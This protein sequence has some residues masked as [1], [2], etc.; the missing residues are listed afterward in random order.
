MNTQDTNRTDLTIR[1]A[2]ER[3]LPILS[4][5]A[6]R[7]TTFELPPWRTATEIAD[8][9]AAAMMNAVRAGS[10]DNEVL[11]AE[12][13]GTV[14][15]CLHMVTPTDF[16]GRRHAHISV[17]ATSEAAEGT[18]VGRMLIAHAERW[19][20]QRNLALLTLNVFDANARARRFYERAGFTP[21]VVK[22]VKPL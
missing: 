20:R 11:I 5:L 18:G 15:G 17:I 10:P 8:A 7:L 2:N 3:D 21:E 4:A 22:Y 12:R 14:V 13:G 1:T 6:A 16:F 19:A 9:D